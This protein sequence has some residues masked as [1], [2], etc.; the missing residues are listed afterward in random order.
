MHGYYPLRLHNIPGFIRGFDVHTGKQLWKFNL[1]PQ[2]GEFGAETWEKGSKIGTPGVGKADAWAEV[3]V[4]IMRKHRVRT[5]NC[6]E[7][8]IS[9]ALGDRARPDQIEILVPAH[10]QVQ[11][12]SV[13]SLPIVLEVQAQLFRAAGH[14]EIRIPR[15]G[16]HANHR[17][18]RRESIRV[19][20]LILIRS[21][22]Q[23]M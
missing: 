3:M 23:R 11:S 14:I 19:T 20:V 10:S 4:V 22:S 12:E 7:F 5:V 16:G 1:I 17:A 6:Q 9:P 21:A 2:P 8:Q 15:A 18:R 13:R